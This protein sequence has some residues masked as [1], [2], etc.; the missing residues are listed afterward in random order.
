MIDTRQELLI[1][2]AEAAELEHNLAC[3]YLFAAFTIKTD[4]LTPEQVVMLQGWK[5]TILD[6][7]KQEMGHLGTVCN[8][9]TAIGGTPSFRRA[10]FPQ[11]PK[12]YPPDIDMTL[13]RL[14]RPSLA[15]FIEFERPE[16]APSL[17]LL[18]IAPEP[19]SYTR[20]GDLYRQIRNAFEAIEEALLDTSAKRLN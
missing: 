18:D 3:L 11:P 15:R 13:Q 5:E 17:E 16:A 2:L 20:V 10:N 1:A 4:G 6:I 14:G 12:Y 7:A 9:L 19:L 8:L